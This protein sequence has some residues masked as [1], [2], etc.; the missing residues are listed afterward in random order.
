VTYTSLGVRS[1]TPFKSPNLAQFSSNAY[2]SQPRPILSDQPKGLSEQ[3][4][5]SAKST[6]GGLSRPPPHVQHYG[7]RISISKYY[8]A[9]R[10]TQGSRK[11]RHSL[12]RLLSTHHLHC[13]TGYQSIH[14]L[15]LVVHTRCTHLQLNHTR[16]IPTCLRLA[17]TNRLKF[18]LK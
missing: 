10:Y 1:K 12:P 18:K 8:G 14:S 5:T 6:E 3:P 7:K 15:F 9:D 13:G 11:K 17:E 16:H 4:G 2:Q